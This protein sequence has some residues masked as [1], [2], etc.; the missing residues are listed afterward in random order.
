[1]SIISLISK[2]QEV[3]KEAKGF[4]LFTSRGST[5]SGA[6]VLR[7]RR[8]WESKREKGKGILALWVLLLYSKSSLP[9]RRC[10]DTCTE[11]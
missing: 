1:M 5:A 3:S 10:L 7:W 4:F 2:Q 9:L 11:G 6:Y 8:Y